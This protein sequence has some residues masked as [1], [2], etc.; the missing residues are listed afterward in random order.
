MLGTAIYSV[1]GVRL[2]CQNASFN[3]LAEVLRMERCASNSSLFAYLGSKSFS[4]A[5]ATVS[6]ALMTPS[7][8]KSKADP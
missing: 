4:M 5:L 1:Y 6:N 8:T 3:P 7:M 2:V